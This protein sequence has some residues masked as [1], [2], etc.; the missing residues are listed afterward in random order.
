MKVF[1]IISDAIR[2]SGGAEKTASSA[3]RQ[4][5][6][7]YGFDCEM[8]S[9]H[10]IPHNEFR[11]GLRVRSFRDLEE[12]TQITKLERPDI[13]IASGRDAVMAFKVGKRFG[14]PCI[15]SIHD[16]EFSPPN[17]LEQSDWSIHPGFTPLPQ[18]DIDFVL[19]SADHVFTCSKF[20][21]QHLLSKSQVQSDVLPNAWNEQDVLIDR[22]ARHEGRY[23]T[24]VCSSPHKGVD[25][26]LE[27]ARRYPD[28]PFMLAGAPSSEFPPKTIEAAVACHNVVLPG[29]LPPRDFL[30][31]S[32]LVL[33]PSQLPEPFGRLAVEAMVNRIPMLASATGGLSETIGDRSF[34]V[35]SYKDIDVWEAR[36]R[37][38]LQGGGYSSEQL[39]AAQLRAQAMLRAQPAH[40]LATVIK[41]LSSHAIPSWDAK[42]VAFVGGVDGKESNMIVNVAWARELTSRGY[43]TD[44]SMETDLYADYSI[45]H[46]YS[47]D[48]ET[49]IPPEAGHY[50]ACRTSDFGPYPRN[51]ADKIQKEFDQLWVYT[52][53]IAEQAR[54]SGID[55]DFIRV[56]PLGIDPKLFR[57][58][59]PRSSYI[60]PD[61]FTFLFVGG[62]VLR[63]GIDTM[64]KAYQSAFSASDKV[65]LLIKGNSQNLH[66]QGFNDV[67][68]ILADS[69]IKDPPNIIHIDD[70]LDDAELAAMFRSCDVGV[71]P[72]RAEGFALPIAEA[73]ASGTPA[74]V[75]QFG[76]CLDFCTEATSFFV[77]ARRIKLPYPKTFRLAAGFVME[78]QSVDFG[79]VRVRDLAAKMREVFEAGRPALESKRQAGFRL[80]Q[81]RLS[82]ANSVDRMEQCLSEL[83]GT[84]P[85]RFVNSRAAKASKYRRETALREL[86]VQTAIHRPK[87][88]QSG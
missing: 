79:E 65:S 9:W 28:E 49:F 2:V 61:D 88:V 43:K 24:A 74:I 45:L 50:I 19:Q 1:Y 83:E 70:H 3:L 4:L 80:V 31:D 14:L 22:N 29:L 57:A 40:M 42:S 30:A 59:G 71:F 32:K 26:F 46:D 41:N 25:V 18:A 56:V 54:A 63:K 7:H 52:D 87:K 75:P 38:H 48:F 20:L 23:I 35:E 15:L 36:L 67:E 53:W 78:V 86:A 76:A 77:P 44:A 8:L 69:D 82:W 81:E 51:W 84:V 33:I 27:L 11:S 34:G 6:D 16:F 5:R 60:P 55:P 13:F 10:P 37:E 66:Y 72:Y 17:E 47:K 68:E 62:A 73:M 85:R 21:Q 58:D 64:I 12:L 39:D